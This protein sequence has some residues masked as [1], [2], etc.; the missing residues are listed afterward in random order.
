MITLRRAEERRHDRH[1]KR[2]TWFTFHPRDRADSRADRF[3]ELESLR[4]S[5]LPPGT[6]ISEDAYHDAEIVTYVREGALALG[7]HPSR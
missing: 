5:R 2:D 3:G 1:R 6:V 7:R 4:E